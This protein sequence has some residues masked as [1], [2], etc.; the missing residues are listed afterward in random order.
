[1]KKMDYTESCCPVMN[2]ESKDILYT[3]VKLKSSSNLNIKK[4]RR[5]IQS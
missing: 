4:R 3:S 1:M 2:Y 5:L